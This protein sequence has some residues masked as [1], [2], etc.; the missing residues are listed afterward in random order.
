MSTAIPSKVL[1]DDKFLRILTKDGAR[2]LNNANLRS[3][4]SGN[5]P[6]VLVYKWAPVEAYLIQYCGGDNDCPDGNFPEDCTHFICHALNKADV[7]VEDRSASCA[8]GVCIRVNDLATAFHDAVTTYSINVKSI[9]SHDQTKRGDFCFIPEWFGLRKSHA[10]VLADTA[11]DSGASVYGHTN[12]RCAEF[13]AFEGESLK[14]Y[15]INDW[16]E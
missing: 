7:Y 14:Y 10:L 11:T 5:G 13:V 4:A 6:G 8:S 12:F 3:R 15:R 9:G 16:S 1:T 2:V